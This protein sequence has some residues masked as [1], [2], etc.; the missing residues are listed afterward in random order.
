MSLDQA[1][2]VNDVHSQL[3]PTWVE[4]IVPIDS[5]A[6]IQ[7]AVAT[8]RVRGKSLSIAGSRHAMGAQQFGSDSILLDMR[9]LRRVLA[10][11]AEKG[12]VEVEAGIQWP[13]LI[14]YL[15][16]VQKD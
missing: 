8:A 14:E 10:F 4:R 5:L 15:G 11:D 1:V 9:P 13:E 6:A 16:V 7:E 12:T 2:F 3:N